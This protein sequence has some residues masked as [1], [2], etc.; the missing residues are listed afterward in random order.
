MCRLISALIVLVSVVTVQSMLVP[1]ASMQAYAAPP[2]PQEENPAGQEPPVV[3]PP[4]D[5]PRSGLWGFN[6]ISW[7]TEG[8]RALIETF[9]AWI[10]ES[11]V[12]LAGTT[13]RAS[14]LSEYH[15]SP[16]VHQAW[17]VTRNLALAAVAAVLSWAALRSLIAPAVGLHATNLRVLLPRAALTV[18]LIWF[19]YDLVA[20]LLSANNTAVRYFFDLAGRQEMENFLALRT[21]I[22]PAG[23]TATLPVLVALLTLVVLV[24]VLLLIVQYFLRLMQIIVLTVLLPLLALAFMAEEYSRIWAEA[25]AELVAVVFW[26]AVQALAFWLFAAL[27]L[28]PATSAGQGILNAL[29][30]AAFLWYILKIPELVRRLAHSALVPGGSSAGTLVAYAA[31]RAIAYQALRLV[32]RRP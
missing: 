32:R 23:I 24:L 19:S 11:W 12:R 10:I 2:T 25:L 27:L 28:G 14:V 26:Q 4:D 21:L 9:L 22:S 31:G 6:P 13:L 16:P 15:F 20:A 3:A 17:Q 5:Q 30:A 8:F 7:L 1:A 18:G 29:L